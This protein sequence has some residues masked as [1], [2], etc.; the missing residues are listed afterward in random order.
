MIQFPIWW[1]AE[2]SQLTQRPLHKLLGDMWE[3]T[4]VRL[5]PLSRSSPQRGPTLAGLIGG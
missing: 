3:R 1:Q 4:E 5:I 2:T